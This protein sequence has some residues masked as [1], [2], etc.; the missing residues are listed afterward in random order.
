MSSV[1]N[2]ETRHESELP[3]V[4]DF[5]H[6]NQLDVEVLVQSNTHETGSRETDGQG[7]AGG[8]ANV[9]GIEDNPVIKDLKSNDERESTVVPPE[10][11]GSPEVV[12]EQAS[13]SEAVPSPESV[14]RNSDGGEGETAE[15]QQSKESEGQG[16][17]VGD[18]GSQDQEGG[19]ERVRDLV[20]PEERAAEENEGGGVV[21]SQDQGQLQVEE[22]RKRERRRG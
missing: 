18:V 22:R 17:E 20:S 13:I 21:A 3:I 11:E 8:E 6:S 5:E 1:C 10:Q 16:E 19:S 15:V 4:I 2:G 14:L 12:E 9:D 7:E